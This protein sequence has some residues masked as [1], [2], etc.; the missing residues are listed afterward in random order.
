VNRSWLLLTLPV[1]LVAAGVLGWTVRSLLRT[2]R[3]AVVLSV[4][5]MPRQVVQFERPGEYSLNV[6]ADSLTALITGLKFTLVDTERRTAIPL[7]TAIM[8]TRVS[9][10]SRARRELYAFSIAA[11]GS[12]VLRAE[13]AD[14]SLLAGHPSL[15]ITRPFHG[16]LVLHVLGL[17]ASGALL[18]GSMVA[19]GLILSGRITPPR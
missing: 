15:V 7:R 14:E 10:F 11:A 5:M 17:V 4:P 16:A 6:E 3:G 13:G 18:I 9:S 19:T 8:R 12:Y 1:A 2:V